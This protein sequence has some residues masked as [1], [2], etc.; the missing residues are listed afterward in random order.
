MRW[1]VLTIFL[2][3]IDDAACVAGK[4]RQRKKRQRVKL[5]VACP[6]EHPCEEGGNTDETE[7]AFCEFNDADVH[8]IIP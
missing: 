1:V 6:G 5:D 8:G 2:D 3:C 4:D 7:D